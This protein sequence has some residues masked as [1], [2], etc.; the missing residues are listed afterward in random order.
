MKIISQ[1]LAKSEEGHENQDAV[2]AGTSRVAIA[3]GAGGVGA[4]CGYWA[5]AL[6][7]Q[8]PVAPIENLADLDAWLDAWAADFVEAQAATIADRDYLRHKFYAQG[9]AATLVAA[10]YDEQAQEIDLM[11]Y[12]DS[13]YAYFCGRRWHF[14]PQRARIAQYAELP[15]LLN[16]N[17]EKSE[18]AGFSH[19]RLPLRR[20]ARLLLCSDA[21]GQYALGLYALAADAAQVD[22]LL[23]EHGAAFYVLRKLR[24]SGKTWADFVCDWRKILRDA[25]AFADFVQQ[26][27]RAG[28]IEDDDCT[29]ALCEWD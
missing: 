2:Y 12:G 26:G 13:F 23:A 1:S 15:Y 28:Y 22:A 4:L 16:W 20:G 29:A 14:P 17:A 10:W 8:L 18:A 19:Q 25:D 5:Q 11:S 27:Q 6:V 3:D 9:S 24:D 21:L 7:Q